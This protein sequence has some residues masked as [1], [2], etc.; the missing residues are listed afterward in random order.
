MR[1]SRKVLL[2]ISYY[3]DFRRIVKIDLNGPYVLD[4]WYAAECG[5]QHQNIDGDH[6]LESSSGHECP[7][8]PRGG[9]VKVHTAPETVMNLSDF[10]WPLNRAVILLSGK[11]CRFA[12][13][14]RSALQQ[15]AYARSFQSHQICYAFRS[16]ANILNCA[17]IFSS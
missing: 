17:V 7:A 8:D 13:L 12:G 4:S 11:Y 15:T 10:P 16:K 2:F 1:S 3:R 6:E 5:Q 9:P 14:D